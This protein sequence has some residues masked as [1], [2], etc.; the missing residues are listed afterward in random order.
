MADRVELAQNA[1]RRLVP[2]MVNGKPQT[3]YLGVG[4]YQ[5]RGRKAAPPVTSAKDYP[6]DGDKRVPNL[7]TALRKC[8][9]RNGMVISNHHHL[10]DVDAVELMALQAAAGMEVKDLMWFP[11]PSFHSYKGAIE[12]M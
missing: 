12:L 5:P 4:Q 10:R 8:G 1:A 11:S 7:E 9:L 2:A 3:P 6:E